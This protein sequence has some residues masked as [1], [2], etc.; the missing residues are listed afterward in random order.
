M[1]R[2]CDSIL[3]TAGPL[4]ARQGR[5]LQVTVTRATRQGLGLV[6]MALLAACAGNQVRER[7]PA[8]ITRLPDDPI[9]AVRL[10]DDIDAEAARSERDR[11][12]SPP[13]Q[14]IVV[15]V[16]KGD[17][18]VLRSGWVVRMLSV[19]V[20]TA[21]YGKRQGDYYGKEAV[22]Y[23]KQRLIGKSV[24]LEFDVQTMDA[25]NRA[26]AYVWDSQGSVNESL[27]QQG[28]AVAVCF[29]PNFRNCGNYA[30]LAREAI[31][32]RVGLWNFDHHAFA[33]PGSGPTMPAAPKVKAVVAQVLDGD[34]VKLE[35]GTVVRYIGIDAPESEAIWKNNAFGNAAYER[36]RQLVE[37]KEVLLEYDVESRDPRGRDLAYIYV[38]DKMVNQ[39]LVEE[40]LVWVAVFPPNVRNIRMLFDAQ[41]R[42]AE[43]KRGI[44]KAD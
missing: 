44:W 41:E 22:E 36:N 15:D 20:P 16:L 24:S 3:G 25:Y 4:R 30:R 39:T 27:L 43:A 33:A 14:D 29:P 40:G 42:A 10:E 13:K 8:R 38:G 31:R 1:L 37:G 7:E 18:I 17:E 34:T 2:G 21:D 35:D 11:L 12:K 28:M 32:T 19:D 23:I 26:L 6:L 9:R 5:V